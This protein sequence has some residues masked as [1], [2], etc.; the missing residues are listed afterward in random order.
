MDCHPGCAKDQI[1]IVD[2]NRF[3]TTFRMTI[4]LLINTTKIIYENRR[5]QHQRLHQRNSQQ[6]S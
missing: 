4:L 5:N 2:A 1:S 3:F 6:P